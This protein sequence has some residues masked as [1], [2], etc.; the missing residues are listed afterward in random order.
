MCCFDDLHP[1]LRVLTVEEAQAL[2]S[3][4]VQTTQGAFEPVRTGRFYT[5]LYSR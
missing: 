5:S 2:H 3:T 4:L 1:Y